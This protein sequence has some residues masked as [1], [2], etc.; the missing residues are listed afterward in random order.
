MQSKNVVASGAQPFKNHKHTLILI[1]KCLQTHTH[2]NKCYTYQ[3]Q[4]H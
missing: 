3:I 4:V 1:T 2:T